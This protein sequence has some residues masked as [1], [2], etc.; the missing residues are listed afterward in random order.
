VRNLP[1]STRR[2]VSLSCTRPHE[3][4]FDVTSEV[5]AGVE[6]SFTTFSAAADEATFSRI[7]AGIHFRT[8]LTAGQHLGTDVAQ[9]VLDTALTPVLR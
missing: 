6:R 3:F 2:V 1:R 5:V 8:D 4:R 9:H 7:F